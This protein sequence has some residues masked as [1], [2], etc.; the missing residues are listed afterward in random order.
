MAATRDSVGGTSGRPSPQPS[1]VISVWTSDQSSVALTSTQAEA[2]LEAVATAGNCVVSFSMISGSAA[3]T[4]AMTDSIGVPPIGWVRITVGT[5]G[6]P[7]IFAWLRA[8]GMN[9]L[10]ISNTVGNP[11]FSAS[12]E[13]WTL[14]DV[15]DPQSPSALITTSQFRRRPWRI[16]A[17]A[18]IAAANLDAR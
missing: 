14:H 5:L 18:G 11:S 15:Q 13:S 10:L 6:M 12:T 7:R 2:D 3:S 16:C 8:S 17:S 4:F 9:E 1:S